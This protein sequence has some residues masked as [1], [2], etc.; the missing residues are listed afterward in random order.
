MTRGLRWHQVE[1]CERV[2]RE[3]SALLDVEDHQ[4]YTLEVS[5]P[6]R[7]ILTE[8]HYR[9]HVG[10]RVHVELVAPRTVTVATQAN[11]SRG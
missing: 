3:F 4:V 5:S 7:P 11:W 9:R 6:A 10:Q 1:D 2:S 8:A